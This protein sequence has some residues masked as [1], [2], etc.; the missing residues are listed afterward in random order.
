MKKIGL[1]VLVFLSLLMLAGCQDQELL[2]DG[3]SFT[4]EVVSIEGTTLWSEDIIFVENDDRMTIE[5]LDEAIDLDYSTSQYGSY[6]NGVGGFYPTEYGVTYN[7]YYYILVNGVGSDVGIDQIVITEDMVITFQE[8]SGFDEIDLK[9]DALVYAYVDAYRDM[10][11]TDAAINHYIVAALGQLAKRGYIDTLT[12]PSYTA[13]VTTIQEAFKTAVFQKTFGLDTS[14]TLT[15]LNGFTSTDSYSA[16][17]HLSALSL[18]E[19]D[20]Q[21]IN[22]LLDMLTA[23]TI[24]DAEYAGMLMQALSPYEQDVNSVNTAINLLVPVIQNN[25]TT[26][27]I[28]SWGSPSSSATAMVV[29]G[30]IA[31]G[32]N[33]RG[34]DFSTDHVDLIEALLL[35]ETDGYFK[36][37]LSNESADMLFSS[38]QVFAALVTYKIFR[39]VW[40]TPAF[41]LFNI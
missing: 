31:K 13:N 3:P 37:Q 8:T 19:G 27:G 32:I 1:A 15:A 16:V 41:D 12:P 24:D 18:L 39:D 33:P 34:D 11:I 2:N 4:V 22:D 26:S 5:I 40:G 35:Y 21:E 10:Y 7:Y 28:T 29:I 30:L 17:S 36:W 25:L 9:V 20:E 38:P 23:L 14:A 6:V